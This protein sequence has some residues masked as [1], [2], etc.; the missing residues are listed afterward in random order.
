MHFSQAPAWVE[1]MTVTAHR[2]RALLKYGG[3][4]AAL[5]G[6]GFG[7]RSGAA[8]LDARLFEATS[9]E[10]VLRAI[11]STPIASDAIDLVLPDLSENGAIV[12]VSVESSLGGT[13][14]I[15]LL[16]ESNPYPLAAR[17]DIAPN[18]EPFVSTRLKLAQ[19]GTVVAIVEA[20]GRLYS[21]SRNTRV[22]LGGCGA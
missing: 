15:A 16:V 7:T 19:S 14:Q 22:V 17:F 21:K 8:G 4:V 20:N 3:L 11:G 5:I 6:C 10:D 2:R 13:R 9:M 12:P 18:T 1:P